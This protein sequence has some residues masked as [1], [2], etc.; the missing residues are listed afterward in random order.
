M[1]DPWPPWAPTGHP[2]VHPGTT[3][4]PRRESVL[5]YSA[6]STVG[7]GRGAHFCN[8]TF[9]DVGS[10]IVVRLALTPAGCII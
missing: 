9:Q 5:P 2:W 4:A 3:A 1:L 8:I 10:G 7:S 6:V